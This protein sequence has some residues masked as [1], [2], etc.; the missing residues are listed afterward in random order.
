[1]RTYNTYWYSFVFRDNASIYHFIIMLA[2][3]QIVVGRGTLYDHS[4]VVSVMLKKKI[5]RK[6]VVI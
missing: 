2:Y 4:E 6:I 1:M 3:W 5:K